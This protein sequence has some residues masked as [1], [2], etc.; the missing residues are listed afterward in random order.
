MIHGTHYQVSTVDNF[1]DGRTWGPWL[2]YLN[3]GSKPDASRRAKQEFAEWPYP[4]LKDKAYQARGTVRGTLKLSD[5]RRCPCRGLLGRQ[6]PKQVG[7][8]PRRRLLL[9]RLYRRPLFA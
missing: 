7:P 6:P 4:W 9:H 1:A 3:D 8:R 2:G 5:G